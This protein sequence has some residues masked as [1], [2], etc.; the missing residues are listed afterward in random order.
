MPEDQT[1]N[2]AL[3]PR[4]TDVDSLPPQQRFKAAMISRLTSPDTII[5]K[6]L[7]YKDSY[8]RFTAVDYVDDD[9]KT[10]HFMLSVNVT[11]EL[12]HS[13]FIGIWLDEATKEVGQFVMTNDTPLTIAA[14]ILDD[15]DFDLALD[16]LELR[17]QPISILHNSRLFIDGRKPMDIGQMER[18]SERLEKGQVNKNLQEAHMRHLELMRASRRVTEEEERGLLSVPDPALPPGN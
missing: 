16:E 4:Q 7:Q 13:N 11:G 10:C 2:D 15:K 17:G 6:S 5:E 9:K 8:G 18:I 12:S 3:I 14:T 1:I